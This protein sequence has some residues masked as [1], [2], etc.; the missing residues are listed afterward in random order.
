[1]RNEDYVLVSK[2]LYVRYRCNVTPPSV[3]TRCCSY[4]FTNQIENA[5]QQTY[6]YSFDVV[7]ARIF[8]VLYSIIATYNQMISESL[9]AV[10]SN[11][12]LETPLKKN[13]F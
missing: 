10:T 5:L 13:S 8:L 4:S 1:M 2:K 11:I 9:S 3:E 12:N 7:I 6:F